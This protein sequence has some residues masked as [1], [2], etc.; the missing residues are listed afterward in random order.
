MFLSLL[1]VLAVFSIVSGNRSYTSR[2]H[3]NEELGA[4]RSLSAEIADYPYVLSI[5]N[6]QNSILCTGT[7]LSAKS[8][9]ITGFCARKII[10]EHF[11]VIVRAGSSSTGQ[12]GSE[13]KIHDPP[14][15]L[16]GKIP[17]AIDLV[18]QG[19]KINDQTKATVIGWG[20]KGTGNSRK[21]RD[22]KVTVLSSGSCK[23]SSLYPHFVEREEICAQNSDQGTEGLCDSDDGAPLVV[24]MD[25][26]LAGI[27][28]QHPPSCI[29]L[30]NSYYNMSQ[31]GD[32]IRTNIQECDA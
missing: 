27:V 8:A 18:E 2:W 29:G 21:L 7:I 32:W 17:K 15:K 1:A 31:F 24:T 6:N 11:E 10:R 12:G 14:L 30:I 28:N 22:I 23:S 19:S 13:H 25:N 4:F 5:E 9:L 26:K 20:D 16:D 3:P